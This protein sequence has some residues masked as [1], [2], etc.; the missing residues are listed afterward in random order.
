MSNV[1]RAARLFA[2]KAHDGQIRKYTGEP[3][4][5]HPVAVALL[6]ASIDSD[7]NM[8]AAALLHD[9]VEDTDIKLSVISKEFGADIAY[10]VEGLT[11][12]SIPSDGNRKTRKEI[13][14]AHISKFSPRVK[15]IKLADLIDN[16]KSIV[17]H[18]P[19]F[20]KT[21]MHEKK[22]ILEV[23]QD[24]DTFLFQIASSIVQKYFKQTPCH[25]KISMLGM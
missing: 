25:N 1:I 22:A 19:E 21:Y 12:I 24:G 6:V 23:L 15:T 16:S 13:D 3:Y 7:N 5:I 4:I 17:K 11:D 20:A 8:V 9:V 18:D 14:R 10:L 2:E